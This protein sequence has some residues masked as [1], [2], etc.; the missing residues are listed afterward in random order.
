VHKTVRSDIKPISNL[1][2]HTCC[3]KNCRKYL[4][5]HIW[6]PRLAGLQTEFHI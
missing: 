3:D 1:N 6:Q 4:F 5:L 2:T